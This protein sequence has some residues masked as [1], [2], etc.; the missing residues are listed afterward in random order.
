MNRLYMTGPRGDNIRTEFP[1]S[2]TRM[3]FWTCTRFASELVC[4]VRV[5]RGLQLLAVVFLRRLLVKL[6][7]V[8]LIIGAA[9]KKKKKSE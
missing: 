1:I 8:K 2:L 4:A 3:F 7:N 6:E 9:L 5:Q